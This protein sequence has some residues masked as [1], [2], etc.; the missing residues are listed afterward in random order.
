MYDESGP[1]R[2]WLLDHHYHGQPERP[3]GVVSPPP[4]AIPAECTVCSEVKWRNDI[5]RTMFCNYLPA[6]VLKYFVLANNFVPAVLLSVGE[7]FS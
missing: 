7:G 3:I 4:H 2:W 5:P 1:G 6:F